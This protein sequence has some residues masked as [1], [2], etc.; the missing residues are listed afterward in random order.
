MKKYLLLC[1]L[2]PV[3][4][5]ERL[6]DNSSDQ[7]DIETPAYAATLT[8]VA[9]LFSTLPIGSGQMAEVADAVRASSVNG[10][11]EEYTMKNLFES[12]GAGVGDEATKGSGTYEEPLRDL[13]RAAA[14]PTARPSPTKSSHEST[15]G[16]IVE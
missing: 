4:A 12:P 13:V 15:L 3:L 11:D 1:F 16:I 9:E 14:E 10:Y 7:T 6:D 5:C 2:V 8:E